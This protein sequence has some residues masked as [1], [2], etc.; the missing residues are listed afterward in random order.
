VREPVDL[1]ESDE[2]IMRRAESI[3]SSLPGFQSREA[4]QAEVARRMAEDQRA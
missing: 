4:W 3:A 2:A 1:S